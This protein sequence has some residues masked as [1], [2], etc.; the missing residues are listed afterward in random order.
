VEY[1]R[2]TTQNLFPRVTAE[3][4]AGKLGADVVLI[5]DLPLVGDLIA[6]NILTKPHKVP[7]FDR[8]APEL[9]DDAG[10][11]Y[12]VLRQAMTVGVNTAVVRTAAEQPS[13]WPDLLAPKWKG[14]IGMPSIDAGG[15]AFL[16]FAFLREKIAPDYWARLKAQAPRIY[17]GSAPVA[18]DLVR[19]ETS[20]VIIAASLLIPQIAAGAPVKMV[21]PDDGFATYPLAGGITS[22][23]PHPQTSAVFMNWLASKRGGAAIAKT[24]AYATHPESDTPTLDRISFPPESKAWSM[25]LARWEAERIRYSDEWR[26]LFEGK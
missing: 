5:T 24:G 21:F 4:A 26:A 13:K 11:W 1:L 17:P 16:A 9:R 23:A 8:L 2:L 18:T 15:T 12:V 7:A 25:S 14:R 6:K 3:Y 22:V 19:G 20:V 10:R